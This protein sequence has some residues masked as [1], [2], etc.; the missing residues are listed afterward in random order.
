VPVAL[1]HNLKHNKVLHE[2]IVF[3]HIA[4]ADQ[5]RVPESERVEV[6][7]IDPHKVYLLTLNYGFM[8][9]PDVPKGLELAARYALKFDEMETT[10]FLRR[11]TIARARQ[12]GLFTW[13]RELFRLMQRNAPATV[14]Y[15]KLPPDRV[16]ELGTRVTI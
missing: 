10:F 5:P 12:R 14:E 8:Q 1:L 4:D 13:R 6:E 7:V 15:F 2:R 11:T 3:L 9:E 16:I